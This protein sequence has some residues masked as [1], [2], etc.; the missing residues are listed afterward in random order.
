VCSLYIG[1]KGGLGAGC[2][3]GSVFELGLKWALLESTETY[4]IT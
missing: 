4:S 3:L 2:V 1:G